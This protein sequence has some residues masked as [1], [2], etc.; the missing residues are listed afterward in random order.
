MVISASMSTTSS[1]AMRMRRRALNDWSKRL[2]DEARKLVAAGLG[3]RQAKDVDLWMDYKISGNAPLTRQLRD[4]VEKSGVLL[5][6][7]SEWYLESSWC[8]D[9]LGW[10]FD[11][12]RQKRAN[13]PVFV[14]RVRATD[15]GLWPEVFKDERG[16]PLVGYDSRAT[17]KTTASGCRR[18]TRRPRML[19]TARISTWR[20]ASWR[21]TL[22][23]S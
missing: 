19:P 20:S 13:R 14:V 18:A 11:A 1:S 21:V 15:H 16:H 12:V 6:L 7:M 5:V 4:K 17:P 9:E 22:P 2:V 8:R 23:P 10:F 3:L